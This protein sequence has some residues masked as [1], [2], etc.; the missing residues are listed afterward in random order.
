MPL[1]N[2]TWVVHV[3]VCVGLLSECAQVGETHYSDCLVFTRYLRNGPSC[4]KNNP[5]GLKK[6]FE[7]LM[8]AM[9]LVGFLDEVSSTID[10]Q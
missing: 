7:E 3:F 10:S 2:Q 8:N 1:C 6:H 9:D 4:L 5:A